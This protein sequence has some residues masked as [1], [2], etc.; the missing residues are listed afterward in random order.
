M[1]KS[2]AMV[3]VVD[4]DVQGYMNTDKCLIEADKLTAR[5]MYGN[6]EL[7]GFEP[8]GKKVVVYVTNK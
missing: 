6:M 1:K 2:G 4:A 5:E 8:K 7:V 3:R